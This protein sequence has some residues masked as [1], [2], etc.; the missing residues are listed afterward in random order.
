MGPLVIKAD[1]KFKFPDANSGLLT[2]FFALSLVVVAAQWGGA[3]TSSTPGLPPHPPH[4]SIHTALVILEPG[5]Q[6][7]ALIVPRRSAR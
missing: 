2:T 5:P 6:P 1:T 7:P 4:R 3:G